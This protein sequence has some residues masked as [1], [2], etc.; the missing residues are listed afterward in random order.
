MKLRRTLLIILLIL[1][2]VF[3]WLMSSFKGTT[4]ADISNAVSDFIIKT[5]GYLKI[6]ISKTS[7]N[8]VIRKLAHFTEYFFLGL[9]SVLFF[10]T[11]FSKHKAFRVTF[12]LGL[13]VAV[14]DESIQYFRPGRVASVID[15]MIDVGG[16]VFALLIVGF[17]MMLRKKR[18]AR[19]EQLN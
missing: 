3:I 10:L 1:I 15:V 17:I 5:L 7:L 18:K 19:K 13:L 2:G 6:E 16:V 12:Y 14:I 11:I 8:R 9:F 4:S